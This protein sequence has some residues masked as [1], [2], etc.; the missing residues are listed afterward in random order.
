MYTRLASLQ[1]S[2]SSVVHHFLSPAVSSTG[3]KLQPS[4]PGYES[5]Y[6]STGAVEYLRS[7]SPSE[8]L[9]ETYE[10]I[11]EHEQRLLKP[12]LGFLTAPEQK[13]RGVRIVG[14]EEAGLDRVPTVSFV[15]IGEK[16]LKSKDIVGLFDQ[17]GNVSVLCSLWSQ[18]LML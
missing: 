12:L 4:G 13:A 15:V 2:I 10:L 1:S 8:T 9:K 7:I 18:T 5:S 3:Y 11:A 17:K 14:T 16:S 6:G